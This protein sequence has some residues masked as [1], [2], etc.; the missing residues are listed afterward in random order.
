MPSHLCCYG[1]H[2]FKDRAFDLGFGLRNRFARAL[3]SLRADTLAS[4]QE[5]I[6][7]VGAPFPLDTQDGRVWVHV[8]ALRLSLSAGLCLS[9][10]LLSRGAG[11]P[12]V[13]FISGND[14]VTAVHRDDAKA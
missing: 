8:A 14:D 12:R 10:S 9:V 1:R 4:E 6:R 3:C 5:G 11:H 13:G 2:E 7:G